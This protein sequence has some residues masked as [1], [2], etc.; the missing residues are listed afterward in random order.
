MDPPWSDGFAGVPVVTDIH[1][2]ADEYVLGLLEDADA[3]ALEAEMA[4]DRALA[5]AVGAARDRLL[6]LDL[7]APEVP[8]PAGFNER[9]RRAVSA[10]EDARPAANLPRAPKAFGRLMVASLAGLVIGAAAALGISNSL[11]NRQPLVIAVLVDDA[12]TPQ[13]VIEDFG[14]NTQQLRFLVNVAVPE[15]QTM[16]VWTLPSRE[17]GPVSLGIVQEANATRLHGP[18]LP[19]PAGQQL[20][21]ITLEPA[22]GSPTGRPTG[23]ILGKGLAA[24]QDG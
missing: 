24:L 16:Q 12:G 14:D 20:Y 22:G 7:I 1:D 6:A 10:P 2:R 5:Q 18:R 13:A 15:G 17:M 9:V 19:E 23:P 3:R 8:L 21:E 4:S 11:W